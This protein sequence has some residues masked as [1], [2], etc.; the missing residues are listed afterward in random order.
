MSTYDPYHQQTVPSGWQRFI[1]AL[2]SPLGQKASIGLSYCLLLGLGVKAIKKWRKKKSN[3]SEEVN[4][5]LPTVQVTACEPLEETVQEQFEPTL[6]MTE[7]RR[8]VM[9]DMG[10]RSGESRRKKKQEGL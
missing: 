1:Q 5:P 10:K 3:R 2:N 6:D 9:S 4:K 8:K 7:M